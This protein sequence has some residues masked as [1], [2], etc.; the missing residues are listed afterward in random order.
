MKRIYKT[1]S[2]I[3]ILIVLL[4]IFMSFLKK[5]NKTSSSDSSSQIEII[6]ENLSIPWEIEFLPNEEMLV[7]ERPGN[8]VRIGKDRKIIRAAGV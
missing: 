7:T 2:I 8:L 6:A 1:I 3:A 5:E 4:F